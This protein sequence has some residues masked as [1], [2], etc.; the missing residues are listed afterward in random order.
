MKTFILLLLRYVAAGLLIAVC[1]V[2]LIVMLCYYQEAVAIV[3]AIVCGVC[4]IGGQM[5]ITTK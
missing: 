1:A 4:F 5:L 3:P 2:S